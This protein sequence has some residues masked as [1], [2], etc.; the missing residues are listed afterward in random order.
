MFSFISKM[1]TFSCVEVLLIVTAADKTVRIWGA[2]DGKHERT[3]TGHKQGISD[4]SWSQDAKYLVSA[5]DDKTLRIW[6]ASTVS[7]WMNF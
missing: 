2:Y 5:S 1:K 3:I 6:E 4:V 7:D